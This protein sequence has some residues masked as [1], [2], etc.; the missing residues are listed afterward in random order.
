MSELNLKEL[1]ERFQI[2]IANDLEYLTNRGIPDLVE[3]CLFGSVA[4]GDY[5]WNSDIDIAIVTEKPLTD[6]SLRGEIVDVLD[7][8]LNGVS[9]D[10]VFRVKDNN[11]SLSKIFD[12][13][14]ERDKKILWEK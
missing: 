3:I 1:P 6:R 2:K 9:S 13:L 8:E 7:E 11:Q 14:Y 5:K 10:V 4:R 12:E